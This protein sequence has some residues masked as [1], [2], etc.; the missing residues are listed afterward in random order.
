MFGRCYHF[1]KLTSTRGFIIIGLSY[2]PMLFRLGYDYDAWY[3]YALKMIVDASYI[4][5]A[6]LI[7]SGFRQGVVR[8]I[9]SQSVH[10]KFHRYLG[11]SAIG[12]IL[13][14]PLA[15]IFLWGD[16]RIVFP[17]LHDFGWR[18][19][20]GGVAVIIA[21]IVGLSSYFIGRRYY[22]LWNV[23][24]YLNYPFFILIF[25]HVWQSLPLASPTGIY[26]IIVFAVTAAG[27]I[28]KW[29]FDLRLL[30]FKTSILSITPV[31]KDTYN[32]HFAVPPD[33]IQTWEVGEY[34]MVT[35]DRWDDHHPFSVCRI[36]PDDTAD[37][38]FKVFGNFTK[39]FARV[40]AGQALY[41]TGPYGAANKMVKYRQEDLVLLAGGIGITPFRCIIYRLL[42][43][44]DPRTIYLFYCVSDLEYLAFD[45][46]FTALAKQYPNFKYIKICAKPCVDTSVHSGYISAEI[47]EQIVG[48]MT[49]CS[50]MVCGP[51]PMLAAVTVLLRS[52]HVPRYQIHK[53]EFSY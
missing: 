3:I 11:Y 42:E 22:D 15:Y 27:M 48:D 25:I 9:L 52:R 16:W 30:S 14:H 32:V 44:R 23:I 33:Q 4:S 28:Y 8:L 13:I 6:W 41:L 46:E 35:I 39:K 40:Q 1:M 7:L 47:I 36:Y 37:I 50:Y 18:I 31:A 34:V 10:G 38:T 19:S 43:R 21:L 12:A 24:H 49:K 17:F 26:Y 45:D 20:L 29:M 51:D 53:E 2:L 5:F